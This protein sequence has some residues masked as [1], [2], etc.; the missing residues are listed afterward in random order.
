MGKKKRRHHTQGKRSPGGKGCA[1]EKVQTVTEREGAAFGTSLEKKCLNGDTAKGQ[2]FD[3][4]RQ[5]KIP[6]MKKGEQNGPVGPGKQR[7]RK[8]TAAVW[9]EP[10]QV[11]KVGPPKNSAPRRRTA[12]GRGVYRVKRNRRGEHRDEE[13]MRDRPRKK[14]KLSEKREKTQYIEK[15][16]GE[17]T[18]RN[19]GVLVIEQRAKTTC[20]VGEERSGPERRERET[21]YPGGKI[22]SGKAKMPAVD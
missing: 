1:R 14:K 20:P 2:V 11:S 18:G 12:E 22:V 4:P 13:T 7:E 10:V 17:Q 9:G 19:R 8:D 15:E 16:R 3:Q 6:P 21:C 5:E